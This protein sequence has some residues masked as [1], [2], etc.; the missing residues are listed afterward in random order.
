MQALLYIWRNLKRNKLRSILT[1]LSVGF[2]LALLTAL[3]GYMAMQGIWSAEA[4]K[5][6][7]IVVMNRQ[8]FSGPVPLASLD[9]IRSTPGVEAATPYA[10][11]GGNYKEEKMPFAQFGTDPGSVF[12]VWTE[13]SIDPE[14]LS[15]WRKNR[16]GCVCDRRLA[17]KRKW[18][19]GEKIPLQGTFYPFNLELTLCGTFDTPQN[20]DSL[21]FDWVYLDEGLKAMNA[22]GSGNMGTVFAKTS[23]SREI[24]S[25]AQAIDDRFASSDNPTRTQTEAAFA[26]MFSDMLGNIQTYIRNIGLAVAFSLSLVAANAMA[27]SMRERTTE[28][29]VLKAIGFSRRRVLVT[30]LGEA[31]AITL[32]GGALGV[33][34]GC[35]CLQ[36]LHE[37]NS[38][39]FPIEVQEMIGVWLLSLLAVAAGI[40]LASGI[41][42]AARAAQMSVID[43]L[44]RIV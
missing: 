28:I 43:G 38:Q 5:H 11:Y 26:Q 34:I 27:M 15:T 20:T 13:F 29:A 35:F 8:G 3:N 9:K 41:V 17:E 10:W 31:C 24:S 1:I 33:A 44:R 6:A 16:S 4:T 12:N 40:G 2:S 36:A 39:F 23:K 30:V 21:W 22:P 7:R 42:P 37:I 19:I 32:L 25:V 18:K 14:Q